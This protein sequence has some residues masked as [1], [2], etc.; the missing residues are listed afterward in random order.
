MGESKM[1]EFK[2]VKISNNLPDYPECTR[3][4]MENPHLIE[5]VD[6]EMDMFII[7]KNNK[8][9]HYPADEFFCMIEGNFIIKHIEGTCNTEK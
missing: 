2:I 4:T 1:K 7:N 5:E 8:N 3:D 9:E 6:D